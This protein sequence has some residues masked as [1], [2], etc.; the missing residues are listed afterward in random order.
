LKALGDLGV[1]T[2]IW[3]YGDHPTHYRGDGRLGT[4][5]KGEQFLAARARALAAAIRLIKQ[6]SETQR[7]QNE[8]YAAHQHG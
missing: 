1:Y 5:D 7:L 6:D 2:G 4:A 3:W 8:F